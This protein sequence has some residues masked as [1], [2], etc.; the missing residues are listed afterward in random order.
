MN[1]LHDLVSLHLYYQELSNLNIGENQSKK[2]FYN[3][4]DDIKSEDDLYYLAFYLR[5]VNQD[6]LEYVSD[7]KYLDNRIL[8]M[9]S[10]LDL[11]LLVEVKHDENVLNYKIMLDIN[12]TKF[13]NQEIEKLNNRRYL[14]IFSKSN[15][16]NINFIQVLK[17][18]DYYLFIE[19]LYEQG[20]HELLRRKIF[21]QP[22]FITHLFN[23][24]IQLDIDGREFEKVKEIIF[25]MVELNT[26][27]TQQQ[28]K[29]LDKLDI[30]IRNEIKSKI[31]DL[32]S[33]PSWYKDIMSLDYDERY[34]CE[35][36]KLSQKTKELFHY[37][38]L[39][40]ETDIG[41]IFDY[42]KMDKDKLKHDFIELQ[43]KRL[44]NKLSNLSFDISNVNFSDPE[45]LDYNMYDRSA[46]FYSTRYV[47]IIMIYTSD[48]Y[49]RL[50][51]GNHNTD[52]FIKEIKYK[53]KYLRDRNLGK[54]IKFSEAVDMLH[55]VDQMKD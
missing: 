10:L 2:L 26:K 21:P 41:I 39:N 49:Q 54:P 20:I 3:I 52:K 28:F 38:D 44:I 4:I 37:L 53:Q 12:F 19:H 25:L 24:F 45:K 33:Y 16:T 43:K 7:L 51:E 48:E 8:I 55:I 5:Y 32:Y 13:S 27:I 1:N 31:A 17:S 34:S 18:Q 14:D 11:D 23:L 30:K 6:V 50:I 22:H 47:K 36:F 15:F 35:V 40:I 29:I 9:L 42:Y 46:Y